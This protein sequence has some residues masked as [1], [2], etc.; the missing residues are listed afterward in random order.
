MNINALIKLWNVT[1]QHPGTSGARAAAGVLLGLYNGTRFPMD[2]VDLRV[3]DADHL[4]AAIAVIECDA[5][6]CEQE[7]HCWL[8][9]ISGRRDFG[10]RFE[11]LAHDYKRKG[12]CKREYLQPLSPT[13][14]TLRFAA[15]EVLNSAAPA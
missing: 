7:V 14:L 3:M 9:Q 8:N 1:Q 13:N 4:A 12:K 5:M 10:Q 15:D 6:R 2:L 11:H